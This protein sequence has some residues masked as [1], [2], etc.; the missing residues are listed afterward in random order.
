MPGYLEGRAVMTTINTA[1]KYTLVRRETAEKS[2]LGR[3]ID[4]GTDIIVDGEY[5]VG[6]I[7]FCCLT[8]GD[9]TI[10]V[11]LQRRE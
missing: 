11:N 4:R 6:H 7:H 2:G 1:C 10:E 9:V 8:L 3:H 5:A